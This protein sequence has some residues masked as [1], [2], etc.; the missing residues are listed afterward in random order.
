VSSGNLELVKYF[1]ERAISVN[2]K[3]MWT[4]FDLALSKMHFDIA[5]YLLKKY[6][7]NETRIMQFME[8]HNIIGKR[9][10]HKEVAL[11]Q[12]DTKML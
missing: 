8:L 3:D 6:E 7:I 10:K 11:M 2:K 12:E 5:L 1:A 9:N 4:A